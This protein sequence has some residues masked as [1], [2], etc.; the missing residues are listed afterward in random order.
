MQRSNL[1]GF[2]R[3]RHRKSRE[4]CFFCS[5]PWRSLSLVGRR[6]D[7]EQMCRVGRLCKMR[8]TFLG[9]GGP[10]PCDILTAGKNASS[11]S[12]ICHWWGNVSLRNPMT[13][14]NSGFR[15]N[16]VS[17]IYFSISNNTYRFRNMWGIPS[18]VQDAVSFSLST[19]TLSGNLENRWVYIFSMYLFSWIGNVIL[20]I[21]LY[22]I[23]VSSFDV[24]HSLWSSVR[25][26]IE[27]KS[28][29]TMRDAN[30]AN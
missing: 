5:P 1:L 3:R 29:N 18:K 24:S 8:Q 21:G 7:P 17:N 28:L 26:L 6:E 27:E 30:P 19:L 14:M 4:R 10:G 25:V 15:L 2:R 9:G 22:L 23:S 12:S 13:W 20:T 11:C 16:A